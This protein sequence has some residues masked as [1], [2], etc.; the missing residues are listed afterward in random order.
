MSTIREMRSGARRRAEADRPAPVVDDDG[1]VPEIEVLEQCRRPAGVAVVGVPLEVGRLVRAPEARRNRGR[2]TGSPRRARAGSPS[3]TDTTRSAAMEEDDRR[4]HR[5][6][7]CG[8][9]AARPPCGT[10]ARSRS[11]A[12]CRSG[13]LE[14]G[15]RPLSEHP[16]IPRS[17]DRLAQRL[18]ARAELD[19][20]LGGGL[21][22]V[23]QHGREAP[24]SHPRIAGVRGARSIAAATAETAALGTGTV[25]HPARG[26]GRRS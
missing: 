22:A 5:P 3:A 23:H 24:R 15:R 12:G 8:R 20:E 25:A 2:C 1:G 4:S 6:R 21:R 19:A 13:H 26:R 14:F 9:G 18:G 7:R 11:R 17:G 10:P 16:T